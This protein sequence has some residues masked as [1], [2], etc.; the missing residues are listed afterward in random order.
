MTFKGSKG[1]TLVELMVVVV[2]VA[3]IGAVVLGGGVVIASFMA[4]SAEGVVTEVQQLDVGYTMEGSRP[5]Y[6][7]SVQMQLDNGEYLDFSAEDRKWATVD[8][9]DRLSV[10][11]NKYAWFMFGKAGT[12]YNGRVVKTISKAADA[13]EAPTK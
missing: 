4:K 13:Q 8:K 1:F 2:I 5:T 9:G 7:F 6:S 12:L 11:Y 10:K 3:I